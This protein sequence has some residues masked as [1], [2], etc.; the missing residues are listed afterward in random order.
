MTCVWGVCLS[1][2]PPAAGPA[3]SLS[4]AQCKLSLCLHS[5][6]LG[7]LLTLPATLLQHAHP[8]T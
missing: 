6:Q 8:S 1:Q 5:F 4:L 3:A 2:P 7:P